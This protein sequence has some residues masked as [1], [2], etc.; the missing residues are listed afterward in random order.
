MTEVSYLIDTHKIRLMKLIIVTLGLLLTVP[1]NGQ[2][3]DSR[4]LSNE[5]IIKG[6]FSGWAK[7]DWSTVASHL[8]DGF[9]FT[10]PAPDDHISVAKFKEKCWI[11]AEHI[12]GFEFPRIVNYGNEAF[13]IVHVITKNKKVIRNVEY[14]KFENGKIKA[15]EVFFGGSG[16]GFPTGA[17]R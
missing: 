14:F 5:Q 10:S 17:G 1:F 7:K 8:A 15:I 9:T 12:E 13:A 2:N 3:Q 11:Q 16:Q 4:P 6:Y